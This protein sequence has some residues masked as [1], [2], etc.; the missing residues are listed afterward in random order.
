MP[1]GKH[2]GKEFTAI[3]RGYLAWCLNNLELPVQLWRDIKA[4]LA[5][6]PLPKTREEKLAEIFNRRK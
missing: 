3:P 2:K 5:G 4:T 1:F 6:E